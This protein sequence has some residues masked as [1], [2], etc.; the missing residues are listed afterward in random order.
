MAIVI[1]VNVFPCVFDVLSKRHS[2]FAPVKAWIE[3]R[4]GFLLYGGTKF[5]EELLQS[6]R[7]AR[8][9][10]T[11]RDAG[12]AV[13]IATPVVDALEVEVQARVN[14][15][16]CNDPHLIA[17]LAA[18]RCTLLCSLDKESFPFV[19][20]RSLYPKGSPRVRIYSNSRHASLLVMCTRASIANAAQ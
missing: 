20:D 12:F 18:A 10:R 8:L 9:I 1:D 15:N 3:R 11:L 5:K 2:E 19:K 13:E 7:R 4:E 14:G 16:K 6:Y 17:L